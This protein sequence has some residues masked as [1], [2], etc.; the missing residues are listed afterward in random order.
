MSFGGETSTI[1]GS[2]I[3]TVIF[4]CSLLSELLIELHIMLQV[5]EPALRFNV[6]VLKLELVKL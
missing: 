6:N 5:W 2:I 3:S 1:V 4:L